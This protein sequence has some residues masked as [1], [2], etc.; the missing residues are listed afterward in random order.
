MP[1][2]QQLTP[3]QTQYFQGQ[4]AKISQGVQSLY[5]QRGL[6]PP[7]Q[8]G[9]S[10]A[11]GLSKIQWPAGAQKQN[12]PVRFPITA[13]RLTP[14]SPLTLPDAQTPTAAP[15][16]QGMIESL[17][18]SRQRDNEAET[19]R[20]ELE[21]KTA[22]SREQYTETIGKLMEIPAEKARLEE[23]AGIAGKTQKVT[24]Y[25]NQL[26][27]EQAG[28]IRQIEAIEKNPE[29]KMAGAI[30]SDIQRAQTESLRRQADIGLL[31]SAANR[32]LQTAQSI[33][34]KKIALITEPLKLKLEYDKFFYSENKDAL[35]KA[36]QRQFEELTR[37]DERAYKFVLSELTSIHETY[38]A[39]I[40]AGAPEQILQSILQ[41]QSSTEAVT[42][43]GQYSRKPE[44]LGT[45]YEELKRFLGREPSRQEFLNYQAQRAAA[46]RAPQGVGFTF[47]PTGRGKLLA[48]GRPLSEVKA[49]EEYLATYGLDDE[50]RQALGED[51]N[52]VEGI[53]KGGDS[54]ENPFE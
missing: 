41:S 10:T 24:D 40:E 34:D 33:I 51:A 35:T 21:T 12:L 11:G 7:P 1:P 22:A 20:R 30:Q 9:T 31:Q 39:A 48:T 46:G 26:E 2:N 15:G 6:T 42:A 52:V 3:E 27:A 8:V 14:L 50:L 32:D 29:G 53:L 23:E 47:N 45:E 37:Q 28:M 17:I 19:R 49:I 38:K 36:E 13:G 16:L 43:A 25:T 18:K 54:I 44:K 4:I 5:R